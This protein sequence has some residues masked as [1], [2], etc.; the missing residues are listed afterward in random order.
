[1]LHEIFTLPIFLEISHQNILGSY[2]QFIVDVF[3][4]YFCMTLMR[5]VRLTVQSM[6]DQVMN[7]LIFRHYNIKRNLLQY[8]CCLA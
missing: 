3:K 7:Q 5:L 1:M 4:I 8:L 6:R 2:L